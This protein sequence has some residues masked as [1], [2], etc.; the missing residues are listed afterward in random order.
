[1]EIIKI[2]GYIQVVWK[3]QNWINSNLSILFYSPRSHKQ[4][5]E[6][7]K[8]TNEIDTM[9]KQNNNEEKKTENWI[10]LRVRDTKSTF[11]L[12]KREMRTTVI[13][14]S[15]F[16]LRSRINK[17]F[18]SMF[19][20]FFFWIVH[21]FMLYTMNTGYLMSIIYSTAYSLIPK[22]FLQLIACD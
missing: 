3:K 10:W 12:N 13:L 6:K 15:A 2:V 7:L 21:K 4:I 19:F 22:L 16:S 11:H 17:S 14:L 18:V 9:L 20:F 5:F 8:M 1:M